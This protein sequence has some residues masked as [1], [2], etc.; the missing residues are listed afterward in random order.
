[1]VIHKEDGPDISNDSNPDWSAEHD[2]NRTPPQGPESLGGKWRRTR[3][4]L[5][6]WQFFSAHPWMPKLRVALGFSLAVLIWYLWKLFP[7]SG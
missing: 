3:L 4:D 2:S 6:L 5:S 1:M 7:M